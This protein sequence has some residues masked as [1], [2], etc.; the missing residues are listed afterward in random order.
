MKSWK[1]FD[2]DQDEIKTVMLS[3]SKHSERAPSGC[4]VWTASTRPDG[5]G[6]VGSGKKN[7]AA[8][9]ASYA[10]TF[11]PIPENM[12]VL[13][14]CDNRRCIEPKHLNLGTRA[15]N[16]ADMVAKG[17]A[18]GAKGEKHSKAKLSNDEVL[19]IRGLRHLGRIEV[20]RM[21]GVDESSIR[22]I[23]SGKTWKHI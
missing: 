12:C 20:S 13:H 8:H 7:C 10:A 15:D 21:F 9:R 17:R 6:Q 14:S 19:A 2:L 1:Q 16:T 23:W 5:Y 3:M 22:S 18:G 11:G 4:L